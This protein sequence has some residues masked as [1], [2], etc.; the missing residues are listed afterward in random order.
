MTKKELRLNYSLK[1]LFKT[2]LFIFIALIISKILSYGYRIIIARYFGPEIYGLFSLAIIVI[3]WFVIFA[4][5]GLSE[6]ILRFTALY[7]GKKQIKKIRYIFRI[8]SIFLIF[9][10]II[11]GIISFFLADFISINIFHNPSLII[12]LKILS[13]T[14]PFW[15][16]SIL[17]FSIINA[18]EKI[19]ASVF[20][21]HI[22][23]NAIKII[24][25]IILIFFGMG[26]NAIIFSTFL[27]IFITFLL[28]Y[29][30]SKHKLSEIFMKY[31]LNK[32]TKVKTFNALFSYSWPVMFL[33]VITIIFYWIDSFLIGFFK[34]ATEV[35]FYNAVIPIALLLAFTP[36]LF[37]HLLFPIIIKEYSRKKLNLI[38]ELTKQIGKWIFIINIPLLLLIIIFPGAIINILF[39]PEYI[40]AENALRFLSIGALFSSLFIISNNLLSMIGKSKLILFDIIIASIINI[41]LNW[42]FIPM[43]FIFGLD[44]TLGINGAAIATMISVIIF[45]LLFIF[46]AKHYTSIIPLRRKIFRVFLI[47]LI[48][49]AL[50]LSIKNQI[51]I[52]ALSIIFLLI[53]YFIIYFILL[54]ILK[55]FDKNDLMIIKTLKKKIIKTRKKINS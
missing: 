32:K 55:G 34:T 8:T 47:S 22:T 30:Y 12:F 51:S 2:S 52:N 48:P 35:G 15:V 40:I 37:L 1:L 5:L 26:T 28:T 18:F 4:L 23:Q 13:F 11:A 53:S 19:K 25:I 7:R 16:F 9:S 17:F 27:A 33:S 39:G 20:F 45:N 21:N 24:A 6:G 36:E 10:S 29:W 31:S 44:N 50:L 38:K 41:I 43:P 49:L 54:F 3:Y 46:Q 14:I 42:L